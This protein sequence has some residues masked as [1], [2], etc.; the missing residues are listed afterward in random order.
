VIAVAEEHEQIGLVD[1]TIAFR[2]TDAE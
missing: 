2:I 1:T